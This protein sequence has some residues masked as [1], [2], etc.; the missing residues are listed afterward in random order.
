[1]GPTL[2]T[3]AV[4]IAALI[5]RTAVSE[6]R[7]PGTGSAQW[8]FLRDGRAVRTGAVA[9]C[10]LG[11]FGW[12]QAGPEGLVWALVAGVLVA[13]AVSQRPAD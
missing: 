3:L 4:I 13:F 5:I 9:A 8:A 6:L 12:F 2:L 10:V 11:L 7:H 1:M